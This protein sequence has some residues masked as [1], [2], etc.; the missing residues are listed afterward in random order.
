MNVILLRKI[1]DSIVKNGTSFCIAGWAVFLE[2][3]EEFKLKMDDIEKM[4][5]SLLNLSDKDSR[6]L[7]YVSQWPKE[8]YCRLT[9]TKKKQNHLITIGIKPVMIVSSG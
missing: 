2:N 1:D 6:K 5:Q 9:N 8:F 7:F 4:A 3:P